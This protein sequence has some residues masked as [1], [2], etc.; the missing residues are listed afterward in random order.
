MNCKSVALPLHHIRTWELFNNLPM[1]H[2]SVDFQLL[3]GH[4]TLAAVQLQPCAEL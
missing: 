3:G 4:D 1:W 2:L